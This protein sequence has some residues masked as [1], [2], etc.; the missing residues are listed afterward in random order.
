MNLLL[1]VLLLCAGALGATS[2]G[3]SSYSQ[4][5][6]LQKKAVNHS[7]LQFSLKNYHRKYQFFSFIQ[8]EK[9]EIGF[10]YIFTRLRFT[11]KATTC[12]MDK[13]DEKECTFFKGAREADC[14]ACFLAPGDQFDTQRSYIS[15][16]LKKFVTQEDESIKY[17]KL[18]FFLRQVICEGNNVC[19]FNSNRPLIDCVMCFISNGDNVKD[20]ASFSHCIIRPAFLQK[21]NKIRSERGKG[22][23]GVITEHGHRTGGET[24]LALKKL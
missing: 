13:K 2:S 16:E 7:I 20:G 23:S 9:R 22:C 15:C 18:N 14:V 12:T 19:R 4:L 24:L 8:E 5:S 11:L 6:D 1:P 10:G 3:K 21:Q 17:H